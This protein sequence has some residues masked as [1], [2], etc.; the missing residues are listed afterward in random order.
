MRRPTDPPPAP[1]GTL[2]GGNR[3]SPVPLSPGPL[4]LAEE[5]PLARARVSRALTS[6]GFIVSCASGVAAAREAAA[7]MA[8]FAYAVLELH[9]SDGNGLDLVRELRQGHPAMRIVVVTAHD[10]FATVVL[11]LR[12]GADDYLPKPVD[13]DALADALLDRSKP[14]P[15]VPETPLAAARVGWEHVHR[16]FA[17]CGGDLCETARILRLQRRSLRRILAQQAPLSRAPAR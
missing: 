5:W 14:F 10:S 12:A 2:T 1:C 11:A 8:S 3:V 13:T 7:T 16:L 15:P 9:L 4:L 6:R 17:Q